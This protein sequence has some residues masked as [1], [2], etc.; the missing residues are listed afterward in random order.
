M[1]FIHIKISGERDAAL[2]TRVAQRITALTQERL[3][4]NPADTNVA[5]DFIAADLWFIANKPLAGEGARAFYLNISITD[6]TNTKDEKAAFIAAVYTAMGELLGGVH[7]KSYVLVADT[8]GSAYGYGGIT[9][10]ER[11]VFGK[12]ASIARRLRAAS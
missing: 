3:R 11:Y 6:E 9:Q 7:E 8:S 5:I 1:P 2:A 10:E 12:P 4:K